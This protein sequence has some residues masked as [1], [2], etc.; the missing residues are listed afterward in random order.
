MSEEQGAARLDGTVEDIRFRNE[1][2]GYTVLEIGCDDELV[3]AVGTFSDISVGE[4]VRLSGEWVFHPTFG[5]QFKVAAFERE[6]PATT[7]QLYN[8]L[9][10]GAVKGIGPATAEK[11]VK[12]FGERTF[13]V[14]ENEPDKLAAI[15]GIS[16]D[17]AR[18]IQKNFQKQFAERTVMLA[19]E[20]YG[21]T[22]REC[23][24]AYDAFG[25]N[26]VERVVQNPFSLCDADARIGFERAEA[27]AAALPQPPA[28]QLRLQAGIVHIL[29][30]NLNDNGHTCIPRSKVVSIAA[31][32]LE[33]S[34]DDVERELDG[35]LASHRLETAELAGRDFIFLPSA[36]RDEKSIS[37]R[38][39]V[40]L[41]FPPPQSE[42][43]EQ[44]IA[45]LERENSISYAETQRTA[46]RTAVERG[47]LILTG[48]PGTG[49]TTTL[50]GILQ[51]FER[52]GLDIAL[53]APTGRAAKRMTE[54]TGRDAKT[55]HR[56]LEVEWDDHDRAVFKRGLRNPLECEALILD[57]LSMVDIHL[58]AS[59]LQ[60]LPFGCRLILVG[61][62]DQLPPVGAGNVLADLIASELLP[63]VCLTEV[64]RQA[65]GSLIVTN[66]HRIVRGEMP[67]LDRKDGDFFLLERPN[68]Y[69]AARA[70]V[71][72]VA[73]RL[74]QAYGLSPTADIQV[75]CP[76]KKG[77]TGT[78]HLNTLLQNAVNPPDGKKAELTVGFRTF[79]TGDKVMQTKNNYDMLWE[80]PDGETG[81]GIFNGDIGVIEQIDLRDGV[82]RIRFDDR[83]VL[84]AKEQ[85]TDMELAYAV[86]VHKSQGSEFPAVVLPVVGVLP[87]LQYR[88]LLYTAVTRAKQLLI[89]V[90]TAEET[91][92]MVQND[93]KT[94]RYS[95][96]Q[97]FLQA[98]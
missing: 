22:P 68:P 56:L 88:N 49:K 31:A 15:K 74:P 38:I 92:A 57:E 54:L 28:P 85:L 76:S 24:A 89:L 65:M 50:K 39:R 20:G 69:H 23:I 53:A 55:I 96:L 98:Q 80:K 64:F 91:A 70:V 5:R 14:L 44:D 81:E 72:L 94:R 51:L 45:A 4:T 7:E 67:V 42:T 3:T 36:Y 82:A 87:N 40:L 52:Q 21:M 84:A 86:T 41:R 83:T 10:A 16:K 13:D 95:A 66:A 2:N 17:K 32:Y 6:L 35:L 73:A 75:L 77:E 58:F 1:Q 8:Y 47:L 90:G 29:Q 33:A 61:D 9:A 79:R 97:W 11:I 46:I 78:V 25:S 34:A 48:G 37:D 26:A 59:L 18:Q 60:A 43:L 30:K 71:Q 62:A 93:K 63:T 12:A 27:I 19:L